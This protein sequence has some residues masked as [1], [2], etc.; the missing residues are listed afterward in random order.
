VNE[1]SSI[2][3]LI[4]S[5]SPQLK[6]KKT[7]KDDRDGCQ[8]REQLN[9]HFSNTLVDSLVESLVGTADGQVLE[10]ISLASCETFPGDS[11]TKGAIEGYDGR[12]VLWQKRGFGTDEC[13]LRWDD[14]KESNGEEDNNWEN[15]GI[16][17][18]PVDATVVDDALSHGES[19]SCCS[20]HGKNSNMETNSWKD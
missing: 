1:P 18:E 20:L 4:A 9:V 3:N 12:L 16:G 6:C 10:D 13:D 5:K 19:A 14:V 7:G 17:S 8:D 2:I 11:A 15:E